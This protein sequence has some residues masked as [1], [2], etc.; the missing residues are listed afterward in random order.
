VSAPCV[1][2]GGPVDHQPDVIRARER[3]G[4]RG[5]PKR[6]SKC[7]WESIKGIAQEIAEEDMPAPSSSPDTEK[8]K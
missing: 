2:C 8:G 5:G 7:T 6:C 1:T 3:L 4:L